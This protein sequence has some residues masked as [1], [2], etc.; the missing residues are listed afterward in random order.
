MA[1]KNVSLVKAKVM[2]SHWK[3][4]FS[5]DQH[6]Q[7]EVAKGVLHE[8]GLSSHIVNKQ[9]PVLVTIGDVELYVHELEFEQA[10]QLLTDAGIIVE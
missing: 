8:N 7:V 3:L 9:N 10:N 4:V 1:K 6:M 5:S 2:E